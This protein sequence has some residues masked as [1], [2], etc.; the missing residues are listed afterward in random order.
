[1]KPDPD[2]PQHLFDAANDLAKSNKGRS[3][4]RHLLSWLDHDG[5]SLDF[6]NKERALTLLI[7]AFGSYPGTARDAMRE[8]LAKGT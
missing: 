4:M 2:E 5:L 3:A 7:G 8:A 1:M 6:D